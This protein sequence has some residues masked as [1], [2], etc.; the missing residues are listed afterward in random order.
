MHDQSY[1]VFSTKCPPT[2]AGGSAEYRVLLCWMAPWPRWW[3]TGW[4]GSTSCSSWF[5]PQNAQAAL[6]D[7]VVSGTA[8]QALRP[9]EETRRAKPS[10]SWSTAGWMAC[11]EASWWPR[12]R[13]E[14][15]NAACLV[16]QV[17]LVAQ[18]G[19]GHN[20]LNFTGLRLIPHR[21]FFHW[22]IKNIL[23]LS[24]SKKWTC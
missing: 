18:H 4:R 21:S 1:P 5:D 10:L 2:G 11:A 17:Y 9:S 13:A 14:V 23:G 16:R 12:Q 15:P 6:G 19:L 22:N 3:D 24:I 7:F 20:E 8:D